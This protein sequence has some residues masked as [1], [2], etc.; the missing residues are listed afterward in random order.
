MERSDIRELHYITPIANVP[1][2]LQ[3]G[4]V[5]HRRAGML[6]PKS[7]AMPE[8]QEKR[9]TRCIP[10]GKDLHEYVNLYFNARNPMLYKRR[11]VHSQLCVL[12]VDACVLD[13][14]KVVIADGNAA[15]E[16]TGFW[17][18]REGLSK[19]DKELVFAEYWTDKDRITEWQKKRV[20]CAE[21]LVP[22]RIDVRYIIGAYVS[23]SSAKD[24]M[25]QLTPSLDAVINRRLFFL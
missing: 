20:I 10:G 7:V 8:I 23:C 13:L 5:S 9:K 17:P 4:L 3:R 18:L 2:I 6:L 15:S 25:S 1:S 11:D 22:D 21:V 24:A 16:Y 19:V 14:P 12:R